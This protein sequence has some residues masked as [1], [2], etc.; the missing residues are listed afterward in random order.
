M[1][2]INKLFNFGINRVNDILQSIDPKMVSEIIDSSTN[3]FINP[4]NSGE[5]FI[6]VASTVINT[7][8]KVTKNLI[9]ETIKFNNDNLIDVIQIIIKQLL[10]INIDIRDSLNKQQIVINQDEVNKY[11][12]KKLAERKDIKNFNLSIHDND[13][14]QIQFDIS[15]FFNAT[16]SQDIKFQECV[17]NNKEAYLKLELLNEMDI[18]G[19][20]FIS[21]II[22]FVIQLFFKQLIKNKIITSLNKNNI[23]IDNSVMKIDL[24]KEILQ[25]LYSTN[26]SLL[27][28]KKLD[29]LID[30]LAN[31]ALKIFLKDKKIFDI[32]QIVNV[33]TEEGKFLVDFKIKVPFIK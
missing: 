11:I 32:A 26:L 9:D 3:A 24:K 16:I 23:E 30:D 31:S 7:G 2:P 28:D 1:D 27:I 5:A 25:N 8:A 33:T 6:N 15:R 13:L 14:I 19:N 18:K 20:D 29:L 21:T 22:V 17:I 12:A 10:P 4:K